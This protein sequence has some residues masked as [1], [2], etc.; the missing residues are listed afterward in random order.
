[1]NF[2]YCS[3]IEMLYRL[4]SEYSFFIL[5]Y[6]FVFFLKTTM[7]KWNKNMKGYIRG[8]ILINTYKEM[9]NKVKLPSVDDHAISELDGV[10]K[11][12]E[13]AGLS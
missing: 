6:I 3:Y 7:G 1:M 12:V 8:N 11:G 5:L 13:Y 2:F 4:L 10:K 9:N